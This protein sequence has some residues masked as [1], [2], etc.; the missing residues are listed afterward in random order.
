[1]CLLDDRIEEL[2]AVLTMMTKLHAFVHALSE[3]ARKLRNTLIRV[4]IFHNNL[5]RKP[6]NRQC[7][8]VPVNVLSPVASSARYSVATENKPYRK[9]CIIFSHPLM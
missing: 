5:S 1:M 3:L 7:E 6:L 9:A 4:E 2:N 8:D